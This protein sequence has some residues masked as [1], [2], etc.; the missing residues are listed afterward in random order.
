MKRYALFA[1]LIFSTQYLCAR[2]V[3][4]PVV[5]AS[6][7]NGNVLLGGKSVSTTYLPSVKAGIRIEQRLNSNLYFQTGAFYSVYGFKMGPTA[8]LPAANYSYTT[9]ELPLFLLVKTGMPCKPRLVLG[10]GA[11][12][13][14]MLVNKVNYGGVEAGL[15]GKNDI[16]LGMGLT[17]GLEMPRGF[18]LSATYQ[19][20]KPGIAIAAPYTV[21]KLRQWSVG[22][23]YLFGKVRRCDTR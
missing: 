14:V 9:A 6:Y 2:A 3:I 10:A 11:V 4:A 23:G 5:A 7:A 19:S 21:Q 13:A 18:I 8:S 17:A 12:A 16:N 1:V 20:V 15:W 22:I